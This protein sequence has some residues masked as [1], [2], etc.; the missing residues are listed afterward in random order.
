MRLIVKDRWSRTVA[1]EDVT[2]MDPSRFAA[3]RE[4]YARQGY[5]SFTRP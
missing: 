3:L 2:N 5:T 4:Y 1:E